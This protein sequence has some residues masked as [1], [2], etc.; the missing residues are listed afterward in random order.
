MGIWE[1]WSTQFTLMPKGGT[2]GTRP[3]PDC[4]HSQLREG[5]FPVSFKTPPRFFRDQDSQ[6]LFIFFLGRKGGFAWRWLPS[7]SEN[8]AGRARWGP[9][10]LSGGEATVTA[11]RNCSKRNFFR[12]T[13]TIFL[14]SLCDSDSHFTQTS[15]CV[16]FPL[17]WLL[18]SR[19]C[20]QCFPTPLPQSETA[21]WK[22]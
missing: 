20:L 8:G 1:T 17:P 11:K 22:H 3:S 13:H 21:W 15:A 5:T 14:L 12:M 16:F 10:T 2:R 7:K 19:L 18:A 4:G 9:V 6:F